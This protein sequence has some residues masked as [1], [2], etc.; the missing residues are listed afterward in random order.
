M[1]WLQ[2]IKHGKERLIKDDR[3][4]TWRHWSRFGDVQTYGLLNAWGNVRVRRDGSLVQLD[5]SQNDVLLKARLGAIK[6][7]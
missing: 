5:L 2:Q 4:R 7:D 3:G 1:N 6:V